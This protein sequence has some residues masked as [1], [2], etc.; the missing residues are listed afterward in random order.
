MAY[1]Y[2]KMSGINIVD[3]R[4]TK[5]PAGPVGIT[6]AGQPPRITGIKKSS[7]LKGNQVRGYDYI[8][9]LIIPS[10][11]EVY[12]FDQTELASL[13]KKYSHV[14]DRILF[15]K[16]T[17]PAVTE[18]KKKITLPPGFLGISFAGSPQRLQSFEMNLLFVV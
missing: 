6:F 12:G 1:Y 15:T 16:R 7:P 5:I 18:K 2:N 13:L 17:R 10:V 8:V 11:I 3:S 14:E 4:K 9:G